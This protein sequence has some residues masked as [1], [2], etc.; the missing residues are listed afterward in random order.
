MRRGFT[1]TELPVVRKRERAAFTLIELLVVMVIIAILVGLLL[2][3]LAR[4]KE[5]ARKTQCRSNLRQIGLAIE[6]YA[7]DNEGWTPMITGASFL[8]NNSMWYLG[9]RTK[10]WH[11][12]SMNPPNPL[13]F[14]SFDNVHDVAISS[15]TS[16][17]A[18]P[19]HCSPAT[20]AKPVGLG[21]LWSAGYL[22]HASPAVLYCPSNQ[23]ALFAKEARY[24]RVTRLD[25]DEPF[26]T[27]KGRV[28]RANNN[29]LGDY[30]YLHGCSED[31]LN[32]ISSGWCHVFTNY[33]WRFADQFGTKSA[34][35]YYAYH[36]YAIKKDEFGG[37]GLVAD[38]LDQLMAADV[39][40]WGM[41]G[42]RPSCEGLME[43]AGDNRLKDY[44][45]LNHEAAYNV[46]FADGS[47][48]CYV[49]GSREMFKAI[50]ETYWFGEN[51]YL[52]QPIRIYID[53]NTIRGTDGN[54]W[55]RLLDTAYQQDR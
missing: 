45:N 28:V 4:A 54:I 12:W 7:G 21:I 55:R 34:D 3:A 38:Y 35:G 6:L 49:D 26:W 46:L 40:Y 39:P 27:S 1:L 15:V 20:P 25:P 8:N 11:L 10:V 23:S 50:V 31:G 42:N 32:Q 36:P 17:V 18:Q 48:K 33:S 9:V 37:A 14:G 19:W 53:N 44:L 5:E 51:W 52:G 2:P 43:Y 22:T 29:E 47:V 13:Y 24:D 16:G 41:V 30:D